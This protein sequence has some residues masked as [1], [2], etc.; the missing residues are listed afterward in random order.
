MPL[1]GLGEKGSVQPVAPSLLE[2]VAELLER[3]PARIRIA[4]DVLVWL[5]VQVPAAHGA[6]ACA[7]GPAED[8]LGKLER[9]RI[10]CPSADVQVPVGHV[11]GPKLLGHCW[12]LPVELVHLPS[13]YVDRD[14]GMTEAAHT[15]AR[16]SRPEAEAEDE[17]AGGLGDLHLRGDDG[18]HRLVALAG[19]MER[20]ELEVEGLA[21]SLPPA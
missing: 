19:E 20:L 13:R 9:D 14:L 16:E 3:G 1:G 12:R 6:Q 10:P 15:R 11:L 18:G 21:P 8:L 5:D 4:L 7:L 17:R 2:L